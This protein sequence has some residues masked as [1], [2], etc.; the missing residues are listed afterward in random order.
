MRKIEVVLADDMDGTTSNVETIEFGIENEKYSLD[1]NKKHRS[2]LR[3][4]LKRFI[5]AAEQSQNNTP[6]RAVATPEDRKAE[7]QRIRAWAKT[8]NVSV[9]SRG[10]LPRAIVEQYETYEQNRTHVG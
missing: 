6:A 5:D 2:E 9:P 7:S 8:H 4:A 1:L 10:R 3:K